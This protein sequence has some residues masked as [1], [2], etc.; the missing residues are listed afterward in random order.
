MTRTKLL[1]GSVCCLMAFNLPCN[2][3][4]EQQEND[5]HAYVDL[6][7]PSGT[8]WATDNL[9]ADSANINGKYY[10]WGE[11]AAKDTF[12]WD[13][14][15]YCEGSAI[16]I[17]KYN[18]H[19][20]F[21][22]V[23]SLLVLLPEDDAATAS[24]GADWCIPTMAQFNELIKGCTWAWTPNY[25]NTGVAGRVGTSKQNGQTIFFPAAGYKGSDRFY[26]VGD[27]GDYWTS[28]LD[29]NS[30]ESAFDFS[31]ISGNFN[32]YGNSRYIGQ[33]IRAVMKK[34][35]MKE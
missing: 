4:F 32:N 11:V 31:F 20:T 28:S 35:A 12:T 27:Y 13:S 1:I 30:C 29:P 16:S 3:Q 26:S 19:E 8:L 6:Q 34:M 9:G 22:K 5:A 21:G 33:T 7:L 25:N 2:A 17:T 15:R 18:I 23:D 14:Y 24:W 10:A